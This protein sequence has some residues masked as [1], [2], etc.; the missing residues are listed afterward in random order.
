MDQYEMNN[1]SGN[2]TTQ[3]STPDKNNWESIR[4]WRNTTRNL[5]IR[6]RIG[7]GKEKRKRCLHEIQSSLTEILSD[8]TPG[9]IGFYW[10]IKGEFDMR[11]LVTELLDRGWEAALPVVMET[12]APLEFHQWYPDMKL[13]PGVWNIPVPQHGSVVIPSVLLIPLVGFDADN[14]RLGYGGGYYDRTLES[15]GNEPLSIGIGL[16]NSGLET[17]YPQW[18]DI[19]MDRIVTT[20]I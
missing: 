6:A 5:L 1:S 16:E 8:L 15:L 13:V 18:H 9:T 7:I 14:F 17:I 19:A 3:D 2:S 4:Q 10:P 20:R 11:K 12:G